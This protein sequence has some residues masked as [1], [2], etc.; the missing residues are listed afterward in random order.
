[1][2][3]RIS[4]NSNCEIQYFIHQLSMTYNLIPL[5]FLNNRTEWRVI[6][7]DSEKKFQRDNQLPNHFFSNDSLIAASLSLRS[8][9]RLLSANLENQ[10]LKDRN[11][12]MINGFCMKLQNHSFTYITDSKTVNQFISCRTYVFYSLNFAKI[13]DQKSILLKELFA[14]QK[15]SIFSFSYKE[16]NT[17]YL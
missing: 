7:V 14:F 17:C 4:N 16:S 5:F 8:F 1:M 15:R 6:D 10:A 13:K 2:P 9:M 3:F 11:H 12:L